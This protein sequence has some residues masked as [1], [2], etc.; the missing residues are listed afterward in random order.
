MGN[1]D[2]EVETFRVC[3]RLRIIKKYIY[4]LLI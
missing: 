1:S 4:F 3:G 2:N